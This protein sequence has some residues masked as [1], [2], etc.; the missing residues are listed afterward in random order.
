MTITISADD[1]LV[2]STNEKS[3]SDLEKKL[4]KRKAV[5]YFLGVYVTKN[6]GFYSL[7][8]IERLAVLFGLECYDQYW[9]TTDSITTSWNRGST[10]SCDR[11]YAT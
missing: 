8:Y 5:S 6:N 4:G 10:N 7:E 2:V 1:K 3:V 11:E 9:M